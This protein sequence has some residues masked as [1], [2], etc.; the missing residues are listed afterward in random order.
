MNDDAPTTEPPTGSAEV[1]PNAFERLHPLLQHHIVNG[2]GW[3]DLRPFQHAVIPPLLDGQHA[4]V[5]APTAGG[6]TEAATFPAISRMLD[7]NWTGLSVIYVCPVKA[8]INNL[9]PR[10]EKYLGLVGRRVGVWHGDITATVKGKL[11]ADPPD[12]M[13]ITPESLEVL[14]VSS[15]AEPAR[16]FANARMVI[17][18][19]VHAL[20]GDDRGWHLLSVLNRIDRYA[21]APMQR[22]GLSATVGNPDELMTWLLPPKPG[23]AGVLGEATASG[24]S[25]V[26]L[27]YVGHLDNAA[28]VIARLHTQEKRLVFVDSRARAERLTVDLRRKGVKV[29]LTH[30]SLSLDQRKEA[31]RAF[32][33]AEHGVI[34]ATSVLELGVDVGDLDRVI[35]IDSPAS[36]ASFLQRMGRTGRRAPFTRNCLFLATSRAAL[37]QAAGLLR[38]WDSGFVEP[39]EFR[40][41]PYHVLAQQLMALMLE[42]RGLPIVDAQPLLRNA[43]TVFSDLAPEAVEQLIRHGLDHDLFSQ[44]G[45]RL[46]FG[47]TGEQE[48]GRRYFTDLLSLVAAESTFSVMHGREQLGTVPVEALALREEGPPLLLLAG[49]NWLIREVD[50]KRH[51]IW[52]E[53][54]KSAGKV[55]WAG[56]M[57]ALAFELVQQ[58][59]AVLSSTTQDRWWSDR[60]QTAM[61]ELREEAQFITPGTVSVTHKD[62]GDVTVWT[63]AGL[64]ANLGLALRLTDL[65][66]RAPQV[67]N[68][69]FTL[70]GGDEQGLEG[71]R[72]ALTDP[73]PAPLPE[74]L[75]PSYVKFQKF[76]TPEMV[77]ATYR[78]RAI[79]AVPVTIT[80][81]TWA[82]HDVSFTLRV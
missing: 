74:V 46:W 1:P 15:K 23:P 2:L 39:V 38:L 6:K 72:A 35:Q 25:D 47:L 21:P 22:V 4:I 43:G 49:R 9:A 7:E 55:R 66:A 69:H 18:D 62:N 79:A 8:L 20:A 75:P 81:S 27:D 56:E 32:M 67:M 80:K 53:P 54:A 63:F 61:A 76:L 65:T 3:R 12:L 33:E 28:T 44:D 68:T 42:R 34:V 13:L 16:F 24:T 77:E 31:E 17:V 71:L 40:P 58:M 82:V 70:A 26:Q 51:L 29:W 59:K 64:R 36:V 57:R 14:L 45:G 52:V 5:L 60:A 73:T 10:L 30:S 48:V 11:R 19:E 50:W 41:M 78:S 37:L